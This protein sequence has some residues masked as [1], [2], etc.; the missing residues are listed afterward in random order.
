[1]HAANKLATLQTNGMTVKNQQ[2][3][4]QKTNFEY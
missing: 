1:M 2:K 3:Q 4:K